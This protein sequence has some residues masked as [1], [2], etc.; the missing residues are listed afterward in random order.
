VPCTVRVDEEMSVTGTVVTHEP[1]GAATAPA[2]LADR[3][4]EARTLLVPPT[5]T[6]PAPRSPEGVVPIGPDTGVDEPGEDLVAAVERLAEELDAVEQ[7][8]E[9]D[10][11]RALGRIA[12]LVGG[13]VPEAG[14]S[15]DEGLDVDVLRATSEIARG[16]H[17]QAAT[18]LER[19]DTEERHGSAVVID[20]VATTLRVV[21]VVADLEVMEHG[22]RHGG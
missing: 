11:H 6:V 15:A 1:E 5:V 13:G 16:L 12:D 19:L 21:G 17:Q 18:L 9:D 8:R 14:W 3:V 22:R 2:A 10:A 7:D 20:S 4:R